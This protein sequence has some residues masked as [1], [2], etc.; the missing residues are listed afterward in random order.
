MRESTLDNL[1]VHQKDRLRETILQGR[2]NDALVCLAFVEELWCKA[3]H[4]K[5]RELCDAILEQLRSQIDNL[6]HNATK[7][8]ADLE[9]LLL[10]ARE[11]RQRFA[12]AE[13]PSFPGYTKDPLSMTDL[14]LCC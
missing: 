1:L 6:H 7:R 9:R 13:H 3:R 12:N 2:L 14:E 5:G 8:R 11:M 4:Y 10:C